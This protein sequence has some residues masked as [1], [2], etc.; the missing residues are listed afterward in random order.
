MTHCSDTIT[1]GRI[2]FISCHRHD[3][4][5]L[6][7]CVFLYFKHQK[8]TFCSLRVL[9]YYI[10][11]TTGNYMAGDGFVSTGCRSHVLNESG[12]WCAAQEVFVLQPQIDVM[13]K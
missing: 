2:E 1:C 13:C 5:N 7:V 12:I 9:H 4:K 10:A 6:C 3:K 11:H 8:V